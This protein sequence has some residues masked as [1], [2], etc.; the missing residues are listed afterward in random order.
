M[1]KTYMQPLTSVVTVKGSAT[2]LHGSWGVDGEK[3][4]VIDGNPDEINAKK[5]DWGNIWDFDD[6][7]DNN[8]WND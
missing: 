1:K 7:E 4:S 5:N 6:R 2:L 3:N 8:A